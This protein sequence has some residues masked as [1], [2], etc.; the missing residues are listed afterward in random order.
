MSDKTT[1]ALNKQGIVQL[2]DTI[3][4]DTYSKLFVV[5][6]S[7][8]T[9]HVSIAEF[10]E[11]SKDVKKAS[12]SAESVIMLSSILENNINRVKSTE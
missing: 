3:F 10:I 11:L 4:Y 8:V 5:A 6:I 1:S 7:N 12:A 2:S 9:V